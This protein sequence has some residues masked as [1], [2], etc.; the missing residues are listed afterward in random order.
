MSSS[1]ALTAESSVTGCRGWSSSVGREPPA[2]DR[3]WA[4]DCRTALA[5][6]TAECVGTSPPAGA[7]ATAD[8]GAAAAAVPAGPEAVDS[9]AGP[10][11]QSGAGPVAEPQPA[12]SSRERPDT[13]LSPASAR[14][15]APRDP[16]VDGPAAPPGCDDPLKPP[17]PLEPL[18]RGP[19]DS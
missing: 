3:A 7:L 6:R 5:P 18:S 12:L 17:A 10:V 2:R 1:S 8:V 9:P 15:D 13:G 19:A 16:E 14:A 4:K 11:A